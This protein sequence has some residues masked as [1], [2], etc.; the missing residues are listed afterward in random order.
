MRFTLDGSGLE[1]EDESHW[2]A[3]TAVLIGRVRL[4]RDASV[5]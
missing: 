5:W 4:E 1:T 3:P 2:I